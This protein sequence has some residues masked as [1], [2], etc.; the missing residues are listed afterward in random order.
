[1]KTIGKEQL[2]RLLKPQ[3]KVYGGGGSGGSGGSADYA[4]EAGHAQTA[5]HATN[6]DSATNADYATNAGTASEATHATSA[7]SATD[8]GHATSAANLDTNSTDW[9]KIMRKDIAQ[10]AAEVI[11]FAKGIVSTLVSKF[12]AGLK[13]GAN[14]EY[15]ID[16]NGDATLRDIAGRDISGRNTSTE[17]LQVTKEAHFVKLVV[18]ELLSNKGAIIVSSANCVA[19][20]VVAGSGYY[21][22]YF[23]PTDRDGNA[24]TNPWL[25][26]DGAVCMTFKAEGGGTFADAKNRYYWRRVTAVASNET[27]QGGTYHRVRLSNAS[28]GYDTSGT[29]T[30]AKGDNILQLGYNGTVSG[31]AYRQSAVIL[32]AYPTM[33]AGLT[34]PSLAFYRG[35]NDFALTT[36]RFT[37]MDGLSN[38]FMGNFKVLVNG[39][40]TDLTTILA[41][42]DGLISTVQ[43]QVSGKNLLP[44]DGWTDYYGEVLNADNFDPATQM[45]TNKDGS[46]YSDDWPFSQIFFLKAGTYTY[47]HYADVAD[48]YLYAYYDDTGQ[49]LQNPNDFI[50]SESQIVSNTRSGDTYQG[51]ARRYTTFVLDSDGYVC[52]NL[53]KQSALFTVY[54][55]ML[56]AGDSCSDWETGATERVSQVKQAADELDLSIRNG[57]RSTGVNIQDGTIVLKADKTTFANSDGSVTGKVAIDPTAGTLITENAKLSGNL[58]LPYLRITSSNINDY[59]LTNFAGET[60]VNLGAAGLNLQIEVG[61]ITVRLPRITAD[62]LGCEVNIFNA[63]GSSITISGSGNTSSSSADRYFCNLLVPS[64]AG[65]NIRVNSTVTLE[66]LREI[67]CKAVFNGKTGDERYDYTWLVCYA[68]M[69]P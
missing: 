10:T 11:T 7:D 39:S 29:T 23:S 55:P 60:V 12:K 33:D 5:D 48:I 15:G 16:V 1:M 69:N 13:I 22:V 30:P 52:V 20:V 21:D 35:I 47:S 14:D 53:W 50:D 40:Y 3:R 17:T 66:T 38:E 61:S 62:M 63:S 68:N 36:H 24:V 31:N 25:V 27:Y 9:T 51:K 18:D 2:E 26:G 44:S 34:P 67:K 59:E 32:S 49:R 46:G 8:A 4:A 41:T 43:K 19:E 28:G 42:L 54:R 56:E 37:F 6:A 58:Y 57:L 45:V 65:G 64:L